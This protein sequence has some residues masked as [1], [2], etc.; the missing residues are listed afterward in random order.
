MWYLGNGVGSSISSSRARC[1]FSAALL[2]ESPDEP[3]PEPV[4][5]PTPPPLP[6]LGGGGG[7]VQSRRDVR[8][9]ACA[10]GA[11]ATCERMAGKYRDTTRNEGRALPLVPARHAAHEP[12]RRAA[13]VASDARCAW[14]SHDSQYRNVHHTSRGATSNPALTHHLSRFLPQG[15]RITAQQQPRGH[16]SLRTRA[17]CR[18]K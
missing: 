9:S 8:R 11:E 14:R 1:A 18:L 3:A 4:P 12:A 2:A 13:S 6:P 10:L 15:F 16:R 17:A 5:E 7:F